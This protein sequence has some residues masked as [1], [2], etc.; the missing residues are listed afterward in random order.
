LTRALALTQTRF[1]GLASGFVA[2]AIETCLRP[3]Q[4]LL[5]CPAFLFL[6]ALTAMLFSHPDAPFHKVNRVTFAI[7]TVGVLGRAIVLK[8]AMF[9]LDRASRPMIALTVVVLVSL[10]GHQS[11]DATW[12]LLTAK[13]LFPFALFHLV[14]SAFLE[15]KWFRRFELSLLAVLAYLSFT[16]IAFLIGAHSLIFPKF[17]LNPDLG[18][19]ADRARG[20]FLQAVA[21]GVSL[22]ILGILVLHGYWRGS[23]RSM[24]ALVLLASVPIAILATMTRAVW[25]AFA[26][27][28]IA[29]LFLSRSLKAQIAALVCVA[30]SA[31]ALGVVMNTTQLGVTLGDRAEESSPV[32]YREAVYRGGWQMFLERPWIGW[33]FHQ[34]P[35]YLPKYVREFHDGVL[36]PHN[37]YLE[38]LVENGLPGFSLYAWLMWEM[39]RLGRSRV[40][41]DEQKGFLDAQFHR[42]W[43]ILLAVY[44]IN[45]AVVVMSYH[46]VNGILFS[47]AGMLAAQRRRAEGVA[48]C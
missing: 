5:A 27:S 12:A 29:L 11:D 21:N 48:R 7:L 16:S 18:I 43:P 45:A 20:P 37:T 47:L 40:P 25:I 38:V 30:I 3:L 10:I 39:W 32:E 28:V 9:R 15:E 36:Y 17:I 35:E 41:A 6:L 31:F 13:Y 44:W 33:G 14:Q 4:T 42:L 26:V 23:L 24:K 34:M 2:A 8:Q 1:H 46:F 22:N 19:Q